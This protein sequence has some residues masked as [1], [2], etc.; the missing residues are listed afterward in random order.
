MP[1]DT[2]YSNMSEHDKI[3]L[4]LFRDQIH[5]CLVGILSYSYL[6]KATEENIRIIFEKYNNPANSTSFLSN[7]SITSSS[8]SVNPLV[9]QAA[10]DAEIANVLNFFTLLLFAR[11]AKLRLYEVSYEY[12]T[13]I[14]TIN[15]EHR[16]EI[17]YGFIV[18]ILN[19]LDQRQ[20]EAIF[21][22]FPAITPFI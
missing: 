13:G 18:S 6:I 22:R 1:K 20:R 19:S 21:T 5:A 2:D 17:W 7:N 11:I 14:S 9:T 10:L 8:P 4:Q 15:P 16:L 12:E 3:E